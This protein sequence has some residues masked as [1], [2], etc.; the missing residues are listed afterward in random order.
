MQECHDIT[1]E[2]MLQRLQKHVVLI[3]SSS[4]D[5]HASSETVTFPKEPLWGQ[6]KHP[7]PLTA[8]AEQ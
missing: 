1:T 2:V 6:Q 4:D 3:H 7:T 5:L 8:P